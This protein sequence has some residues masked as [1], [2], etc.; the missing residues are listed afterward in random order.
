M[1]GSGR[2]MVLEHAAPAASGPLRA[3]EREP[4]RA[5][6]RGAPAARRRVRRV[7]HRSAALRGRPRAARAAH[8]ARS[9]DRRPRRGGRRGRRR[10]GTSATAPASPGWPARDGTCDQCRA[11]RE[12][13]CERA[14][15]TGWDV[16]GGYATHALVRADFA[17]RIPDGF[18]DLGAAP[19]LCGG[20]IGYRSLKRSGIEPGG[21]LGLYGFGASAL[22]AMQVARHWG[23][24]VFVATRSPAEQR[25]RARARRGVGGRLRRRAARAAR[26]RGHVRAVGR[27][28]AR[29]AARPRSRRAPSPSTPSTS[30]A[31]PR[32][33][34]TSC[35]GSAG[36][37]AS[38]TSPAPTRREFLDARRA[39]PDPHDVRD[40]SARR[41]ERRARAPRRAA[42]SAARRCSF[43]DRG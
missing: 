6:D 19:L 21:R 17:L 31:C 41:R 16:D 9:P 32:C 33:P 25:A 12:N 23:C 18:D 37:P 30:I 24:R 35:G 10:T 15:F 43:R 29:R 2:A 39:H 4:A 1:G 7:P 13:L 28:R 42:R 22:L 8:R 34:T 3:A 11:G 40:A 14:T 26:R 36:S 27:R 38:P 20:V 5:R